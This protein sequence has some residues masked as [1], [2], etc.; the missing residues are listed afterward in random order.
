MNY[1]V[2]CV[3]IF[4]HICL[5]TDWYIYTVLTWILVRIFTVYQLLIFTEH[6]IKYLQCINLYIYRVSACIF[7]VY[8]LV[9]LQGIGLCICSVSTCIFTEYWLVY[10]QCINLYIYRVLACFAGSFSIIK[11]SAV[12][13]SH[14]TCN[15][16]KYNHRSIIHYYS[17]NK[18]I[19][20]VEYRYFSF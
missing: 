4:L 20:F 16:R 14:G 19:Y 15:L 12:L 5:Y 10:L 8:Q 3:C 7:T 6:W 17:I 11:C 1:F 13:L 2:Y 18:L 9:Y